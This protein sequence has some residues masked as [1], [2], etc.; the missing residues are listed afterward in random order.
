MERSVT[1]N[2]AWYAKKCAL[3][4]LVFFI[5]AVALLALSA[6]LLRS[7]A[8]GEER[9][10]APVLLSAAVASFAGCTVAGRKSGR[11]QTLI[12]SCAA[13]SWLTVQIIA[14]L[15]FEDLLPMRSLELAA[16]MAVGMLAAL[17]VRGKKKKRRRTRRTAR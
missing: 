13:A 3:G 9:S 17:G 10:M 8:V 5:V 15:F 7:G 11:R 16:A 12:L 4:A 14:A 6:L 2:T 1:V